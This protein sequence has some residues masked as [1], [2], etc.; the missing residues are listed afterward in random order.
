MTNAYAKLAALLLVA[1]L[2]LPACDVFDNDDDE[3]VTRTIDR[4][5]AG[6]ATLTGECQGIYAGWGRLEL[7]GTGEGP[8]FGES[9]ISATICFNPETGEF[10]PGTGTVVAENGDEADWTLNIDANLQTGEYTD[11]GE[12]TGGTGRYSD[13]HGTYTGEGTM[14]LQFDENG[15]LVFP[16]SL[17][18]SVTGVVTYRD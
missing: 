15:Q 9:T 16:I 6:E 17:S 18:E 1:G 11:S 7:I 12:F 13:L 8:P 10:A 4:E 3:W 5:L 2:L 14:D